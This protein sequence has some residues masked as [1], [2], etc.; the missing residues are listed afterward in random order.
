MKRYIYLGDS[1]ATEAPE[2]KDLF[3]NKISQLVDVNI[4][5]L[6]APGQ[7]MTRIEDPNNP[8]LT[9]CPV[10]GVDQKAIL[11]FMEGFFGIDGLIIALGGNDIL[12]GIDTQVFR[13]QYEDLVLYAKSIGLEVT[14]ITPTWLNTGENGHAF[15]IRGIISAIGTVTGCTVLHGNTSIPQDAAHY[16]LVHLTALGHTA[17]ANWLIQEMGW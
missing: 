16:N 8:Y 7:Y 6:S 12:S 1:I 15:N 9:A 13:H 3:E 5:N 10:T 2:A 14:L 4:H 17:Y 11:G